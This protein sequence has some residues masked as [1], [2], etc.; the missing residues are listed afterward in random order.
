MNVL[1]LVVK[2]SDHSTMPGEA[3]NTFQGQ[4]PMSLNKAVL[5]RVLNL[6]V[7][8]VT[9]LSKRSRGATTANDIGENKL[10]HDDRPNRTSERGGEGVEGKGQVCARSR[11]DQVSD[12]KSNNVLVLSSRHVS[13][14]H[15]TVREIEP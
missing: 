11:H 5:T 10:D 12:Y 9:G 13:Q 15:K 6:D 8:D 14:R 1:S 2:G 4:R 7:G 3:T